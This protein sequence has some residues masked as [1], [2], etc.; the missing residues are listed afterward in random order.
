[1][2]RQPMK[3]EHVFHYVSICFLIMIIATFSTVTW[4]LPIQIVASKAFYTEW[5]TPKGG[6]L[7]FWLLITWFHWGAGKVIAIALRD[8]N[9]KMFGPGMYQLKMW[10][11]VPFAPIMNFR[12]KRPYF[13]HKTG[14]R[15]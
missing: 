5:L 14:N 1:M 2:G 8:K 10:L 12:L 13:P 11:I 6:H 7:L 4:F 3:F 9:E 15:L